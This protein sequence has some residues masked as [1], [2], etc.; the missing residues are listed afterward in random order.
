MTLRGTSI[1]FAN[2]AEP[3]EVSFVLR[4]GRS[5][6]RDPELTV[7]GSTADPVVEVVAAEGTTGSLGVKVR[8]RASWCRSSWRLRGPLSDMIVG[9]SDGREDREK[10]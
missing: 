2:V 9:L 4:W 6:V 10:I 7:V 5:R 8:T 1:S 3:D